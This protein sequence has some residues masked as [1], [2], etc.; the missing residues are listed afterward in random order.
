MGRL[1]ALEITSIAA[2]VLATVA[3]SGTLQLVLALALCAGALIGWAM[4]P[5]RELP[6]RA[7]S[8]SLPRGRSLRSPAGRR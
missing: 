6:P 4:W 1:S 7:P 2:I 8:S 3:A 5:L